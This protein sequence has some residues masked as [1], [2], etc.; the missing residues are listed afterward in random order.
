M[1][2]REAMHTARAIRRYTPDPI[3]PAVMYRCLEAAT[4][5]PSGGNQQP[6]RFIVLSSPEARNALAI[7]AKFALDNIVKLYGIARPADDDNSPKARN[8]RAV[9][10]LH[11]GARDV[12]G[13]VLFC[14]KPQPN[15]PPP[16]TG[17]SIFPAMQNFMLAARAEGLG[18]VSVGWQASEKVFR[19]ALAIP[20]DWELSGLVI[21]GW[22]RGHH[23]PV[24]RKPVEQ[25]AYLDRW[26]N[27]FTV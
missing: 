12:P 9:L 23:G 26:D 19:S 3:D 4:W 7:G 21:C 2:L 16:Q 18:T 8:S 13:A 6:W 22:P 14:L 5:A 1:E 10:E 11:E 17:A 15:T 27:P 20:D 24:R 25:V